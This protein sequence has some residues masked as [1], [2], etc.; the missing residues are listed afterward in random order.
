MKFEK[1]GRNFLKQL[2]YLGGIS[3][4]F[5][6]S[7]IEI[8]KA[9]LKGDRAGRNLIKD[10]IKKQILFTGYDALPIISVIALSLGFIIIVQSV[11]QL[12]NFG[13]VTM[14]GSILN[15]VILR[16]LGPILT[17]IIIIG[18]SGTAIATEIGNMKVNHE[19][20]ALESM[21]IDTMRFVI[22]PRIVGGMVSVTALTIYFSFVGLVGGFL[23]ASFSL[24]IPFTRF[25]SII[26]STMEINDI[27][28]ALIKSVVFGAIISTLSIYYGFKVNMSST[29]VPQ[30]VTKA[31]V[32]SLIF[33]F[34]FDGIVTAM[35][36]L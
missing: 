14:I 28:I 18:R 10:I 15:T 36:Y 23:V 13:A 5:T 3:A 21:G 19:I 26:F 12:M 25:F 29:E 17:A 7:F 24:T 8:I 27:L 30:A 1:I 9:R 35:F 31:V 2:D 22:Y 32:S 11:T 6:L 20:D 34:V 16:E 4:L 33:T